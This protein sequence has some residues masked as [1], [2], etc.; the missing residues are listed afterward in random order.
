MI[1]PFVDRIDPVAVHLGPL[2]V[3]WYGLMYLLG[4]AGAWILGERRRRRGFLPISA[5]AFSDLLF[6]AM[7]GVIVGGRLWYMATYYRPADWLWTDPLALFRIYDGG[8]SFHGGLLGV[9]V[10]V[11]WWSRRNK[12]HVFDTVD[13]VAPL[14]P[15]GL[16]LG[17]I[18]NFINGELWGKPTHLPWAVMFPGSHN[19]DIEYL[20]SHPAWQETWQRYGML[21]RHPSQLYEML[22]EG[23]VMFTVL[24]LYSRN[25]RPRFRVSGLFAIMYGC[26]R[27]A[28]EF[29]RMPDPQ[30]GT[31]GQPG[32][33]FGTHWITM[34]QVQSVPLVL[35]GLW[36]LWQSRSAPTLARTPPPDEPSA[37]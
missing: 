5:N 12:V 16:G 24:Y 30:F 23:V 8:M 31:H 19:E 18:G 20:A 13:F 26:F 21:P 33:L 27:I 4:F 32:Y 10:A 36:L 25:P 11:W 1:Q 15:I 7:M 3:H 35:F 34:G 22:L 9:L 28:V 6:F 2:A 17:R 14:V 37:A 29:V